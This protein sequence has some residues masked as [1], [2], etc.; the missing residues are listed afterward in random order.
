MGNLATHQQRL[1]TLKQIEQ[2]I[3]EEQAEVEEKIAKLMEIEQA[4]TL[5]IVNFYKR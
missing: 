3:P 4:D 2:S 5:V 1:E